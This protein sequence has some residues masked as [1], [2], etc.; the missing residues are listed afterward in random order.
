VTSDHETGGLNVSAGR[1]EGNLPEGEFSGFEHT[2]RLV[3]V[4]ASGPGAS[5]F[6]GGEH[7]NTRVHEVVL[8]ALSQAVVPPARPVFAP[9]GHLGD[10]RHE[11]S[12]QLAETGFG[13]GFNQLDALFL[14]VDDRGLAVGLEGRFEVRQNAVVVLLDVDFGGGTGPDNLSVGV[15]DEAGA[16]DLLLSQAP[17]GSP[18]VAGFGV[19]L[20]VV[21]PGARPL[22]REVLVSSMGLRGLRAPY[23]VAEDLGWH[24]AAITVHERARAE[25]DPAPGGPAVGYEIHI[26]LEVLYPDRVGAPLPAGATVGVAAYLVNDDGGFLSNQLLPPLPAGSANPGRDVTPLPGVIR[27][28]LD[29][30]GDGRPDGAAP[31]EL[32]SAP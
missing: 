10:L 30:D 23:G 16:A 29:S 11:A 17:I 9:D 22:Q 32:V 27:Y 3:D 2:N 6:D 12:R 18:G 28:V 20:A 19:D 13:V 15:A 1:G 8:A 24:N 25:S 4:W 26:P 7:D 14:D 5:A 31:P 21:L